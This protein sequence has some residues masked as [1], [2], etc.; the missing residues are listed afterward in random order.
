MKSTDATAT[1]ITRD[2][3]VAMLGSGQTGVS[4]EA[5]KMVVEAFEVIHAK[6]AEKMRAG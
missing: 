6:V 4:A 3:V 1:E 2:I 5:A